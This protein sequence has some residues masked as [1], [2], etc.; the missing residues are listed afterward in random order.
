M[1]CEIKECK[2]PRKYCKMHESSF[3]L[4]SFTKGVSYVFWNCFKLLIVVG[5]VRKFSRESLSSSEAV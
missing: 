1:S 5:I 2:L 4:L 3:Y